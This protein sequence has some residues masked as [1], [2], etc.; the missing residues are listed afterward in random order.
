[1]AAGTAMAFD[2]DNFF[3]TLLT[4]TLKDLNLQVTTFSS[5]SPFLS[6]LKE[7]CSFGESAPCPDFIL[8]DN[9]MPGM[10]GLEFLT[11]IKKMHCKIPS[12]RMAIIS[13]RWD[14]NELET[15]RELGCQI[16][17]KYNSPEQ[18]RAWIEESRE[19]Y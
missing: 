18:I 6:Q 8:T 1:M 3:R 13:G 17:Q 10:T 4:D 19:D 15:A 12:H 5:P 14:Q 7:D 2:N 9:W 16:F 11:A